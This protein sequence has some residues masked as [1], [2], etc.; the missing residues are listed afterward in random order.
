ME[1]I[2]Y[3]RNTPEVKIFLEEIG[4]K[5]VYKYSDKEFIFSLV[6]AWGDSDNDFTAYDY[7]YISFDQ[8]EKESKP[9]LEDKESSFEDFKEYSKNKYESYINL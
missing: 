5:K 2:K 8:N 9:F 7:L 3:T 6:Q 4:Y 1:R